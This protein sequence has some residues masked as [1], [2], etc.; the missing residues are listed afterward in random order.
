MSKQRVS[1]FE[2][3]SGSNLQRD[4]FI[5]NEVHYR[6]YR[7]VWDARRVPGMLFWTGKVAVVLPIDAANIERVHR[8]HSSDYF[9]SEE[10]ARDHLIGAA[11][12]WID[13]RDESG[14]SLEH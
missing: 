9:L 14:T 2:P 8:V 12:Q 7:I 4:S 3:I 10:D 11:R 13:A 1:A 6:G 5:S